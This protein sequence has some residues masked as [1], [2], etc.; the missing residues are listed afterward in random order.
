LHINILRFTLFLTV[1]LLATDV[2]SQ[3]SLKRA[4]KQA[5]QI[6]RAFMQKDYAFIV[7]WTYPRV[8]ELGGGYDNMLGLITAEME[9]IEREDS[10]V[11][12]SFK[13]GKPYNLL[14]TNPEWYCIVPKISVFDMPTL[15]MISHS[16]LVGVSDDK[17]K[18]WTFVDCNGITEL[19]FNAIFPYI[20][21]EQLA[22]PQTTFPELKFKKREE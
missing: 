17:G 2:Y 10:L 1:F 6:G 8:V 5:K 13:V 20:Q 21:P 14:Q 4:K 15:T 12:K 7:D 16:C 22:I 9:A 11:V 3:Y 19:S 18:S